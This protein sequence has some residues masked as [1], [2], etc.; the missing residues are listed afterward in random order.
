M[1]EQ[2]RERMCYE[3]DL[4]HEGTDTGI[5]IMFRPCISSS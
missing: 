1:V 3:E 4:I 2:I 5:S